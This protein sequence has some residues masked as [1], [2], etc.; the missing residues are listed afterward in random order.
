MYCGCSF[1]GD[2]KELSSLINFCSL[3]ISL[4]QKAKPTKYYYYLH[5]Q[6]TNLHQMRKDQHSC[7]STN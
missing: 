4:N 3:S 1:P 6:I 5:E 7:T 2:Q